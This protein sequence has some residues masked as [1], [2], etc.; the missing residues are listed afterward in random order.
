MLRM[1]PASP[2]GRWSNEVIG[3]LAQPKFTRLRPRRTEDSRRW[4]REARELV[5]RCVLAAAALSSILITVTIVVV[6][7]WESSSFF[8][9]P[10]VTASGF[11]FGYH[12]GH[13]ATAWAPL[14]DSAKHCIWP[15]VRALI[16]MKCS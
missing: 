9:A 4:R 1:V 14:I 2:R 6:L 11:L 5:A 13:W 3:D 12:D 8:G 7:V 16:L 15:L 10:E